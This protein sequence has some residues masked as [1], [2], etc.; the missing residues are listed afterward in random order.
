MLL[1][2]LLLVLP[3]FAAAKSPDSTPWCQDNPDFI[4]ARGKSCSDYDR[5]DCFEAWRYMN[6]DD[7][8]AYWN[9]CE[10]QKDNVWCLPGNS[11][12]KDAQG[13]QCDYYDNW[14]KCF[15]SWEHGTAFN[16]I[17]RAASW[18]CCSCMLGQF[19]YPN[20]DPDLIQAASVEA[21][22]SEPARSKRLK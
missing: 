19:P 8:L 3:L 22:G 6:D 4:D 20:E 9:C 1:K 2:V 14:F 7:E 15:S 16:G 5:Y 17:W 12:W 13:R 21:L 11:E 10:C 18:V